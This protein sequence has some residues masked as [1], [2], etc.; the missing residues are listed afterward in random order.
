MC[1][2]NDNV[3]VFVGGGGVCFDL[4]LDFTVVCDQKVWKT[5]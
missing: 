3:W 4:V 2:V 1:V 5:V